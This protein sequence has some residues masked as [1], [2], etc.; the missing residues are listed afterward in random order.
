MCLHDGE[1]DVSL[2]FD[3]CKSHRCDHYHHEVECLDPS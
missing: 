3:R 2:V 1:D